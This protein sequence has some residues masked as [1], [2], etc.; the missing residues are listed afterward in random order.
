MV[1][2]EFIEI[3]NP[4]EFEMILNGLPF[5]DI[6]DWKENTVYKGEYTKD[7]EKIIWFW[8]IIEQF[9]QLQLSKLLKF[10]TGST[11]ISPEGF[12]YYNILNF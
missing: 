3:F 4:D 12:K 7:H 6:K 2:E 8:I 1:P 5:I 11:R 10:C 9:D